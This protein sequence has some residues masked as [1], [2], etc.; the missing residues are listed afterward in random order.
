MSM[1]ACK[2][3]ILGLC[4]T[5]VLMGTCWEHMG[6]DVLIQAIGFSV[7]TPVAACHKNV[8]IQSSPNVRNYYHH[9]S[10]VGKCA[11]FVCGVWEIVQN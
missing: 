2:L 4:T 6:T 8:A 9:R 11:S 7:T 1:M 5:P 3:N 10:V